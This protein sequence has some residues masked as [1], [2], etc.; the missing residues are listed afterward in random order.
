MTNDTNDKTLLNQAILWSAHKVGVS[1]LILGATLFEIARLA[2]SISAGEHTESYA[3]GAAIILWVWLKFASPL[4]SLLPA[5]VN[6]WLQG[7]GGHDQG[8]SLDRA[9]LW[10]VHTVGLSGLIVVFGEF[11]IARLSTS[12]SAGEGTDV[13]ASLLLITLWLWTKFGA[14]AYIRWV[15]PLIKSWLPEGIF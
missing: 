15:W 2:S 1:G 7:G 8:S 12:I 14:P 13:K 6:T 5:S 3:Y 4:V 11:Q 10:I 9:I